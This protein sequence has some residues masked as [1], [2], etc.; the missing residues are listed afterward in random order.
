M[1]TPTS[2]KV[3]LS[4]LGMIENNL[5]IIVLAFWAMDNLRTQKF[6]NINRASYNALLIHYKYFFRVQR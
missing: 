4:L 5:K 1:C 3:Y 6:H 2:T